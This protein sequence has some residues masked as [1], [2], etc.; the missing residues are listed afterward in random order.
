MFSGRRCFTTIKPSGIPQRDMSGFE[1]AVVLEQ[2]RRT[3]RNVATEEDVPVDE[4][5]PVN[6]ESEA[7]PRHPDGATGSPG[8]AASTEATENNER[9]VPGEAVVL[10]GDSRPIGTGS[11]PSHQTA[12]PEADDHLLSSIEN[13]TYTYN[14]HKKSPTNLAKTPITK[15]T[16]RFGRHVR[17]RRMTPAM[18]RGH[19]NI[20]AKSNLFTIL[21]Q[22]C[23]EQLYD[24]N[25]EGKFGDVHVLAFSRLHHMNLHYFEAELAAELASIAEK[26]TTDREQMLRIRMTLR[27]YSKLLSS[28]AVPCVQILIGM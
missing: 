8:N 13:A 7:P 12:S 5:A 19:K 24:D 27:E 1:Q 28:H 16:S 6:F 9:P 21:A 22:E 11:H 4:I 15:V 3:E 10:S 14:C 23:M 2:G 17:H 26:K 25:F 18:P 20:A